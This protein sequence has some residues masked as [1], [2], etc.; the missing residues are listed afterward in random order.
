MTRRTAGVAALA[1]FIV[2]GA[3]AGLFGPHWLRDRA[4][5]RIVV[6]VALDWRDFGLQTAE[7]RLLYELDRAA[8]SVYV[9]PDGCSLNNDNDNRIV[10]CAW[11]VE[12][13]VPLTKW[14][15]PVSFSSG[16]RIDADGTLQ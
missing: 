13:R 7:E 9:G 11:E 16:A 5:D 12:V 6:A 10:I 1:V 2:L 8:L 14:T 15:V 4:L 3:P